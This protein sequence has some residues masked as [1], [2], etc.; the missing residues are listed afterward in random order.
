MKKKISIAFLILL[1]AA[2]CALGASADT[3]LPIDAVVVTFWQ[4]TGDNGDLP[5]ERNLWFEEGDF[6]EHL[7]FPLGEWDLGYNPENRTL[8]LTTGVGDIKA[9]SSIM[10]LGTD[11]RFDLSKAYFI[12]CGIAGGDPLDISLGSVAICRFVIDHD[13]SY[14]IDPREMPG[15]F[16]TGFLPIFRTKPYEEPMRENGELYRLNPDLAGKALELAKEVPL[17]ETEG[18]RKK[19]ALYADFPEASI[20]PFVMI[21]DILS[22]NRFWHGKLSNEWA[23]EWMR[24]FSKGEGNYVV[25]AMEDA[26]A[27]L[28]I[29]RL[30][31]VG[32]ADPERV[33]I[34]RSVSNFAMQWK[35]ASAYESL[36]SE[37]GDEYSSVEAAVRNVHAVGAAVLRGLLKERNQ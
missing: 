30:S 6:T 15:E 25:S 23:N 10:A 26:G 2:S 14:F 17:E 9:A 32:K 21:G 28:A 20:P 35:G 31:Q 19:R 36:M 11:P 33:I 5:G 7:P 16:S 34:L 22:G 13:L 4:L 3:P 8:L 1:L 12:L 18:L 24:Y 37:G 27:M 29:Q